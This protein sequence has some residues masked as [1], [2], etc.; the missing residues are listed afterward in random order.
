M[1]NSQ[2]RVQ[3]QMLQLHLEDGVAVRSRLQVKVMRVQWQEPLYSFGAIFD[4][5]G[6][7]GGGAD[8]E[9][10]TIFLLGWGDL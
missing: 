8:Y 7:G 6:G 5:C 10:F 3:R 9:I 4:D 2:A 1:V